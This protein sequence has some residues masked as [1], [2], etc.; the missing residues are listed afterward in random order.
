MFLGSG[1]ELIVFV[2]VI[3]VLCVLRIVGS[4]SPVG[5]LKQAWGRGGSG[6]QLYATTR[7]TILLV[8][9]LVAFR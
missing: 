7:R 9:Y 3:C 6:T 5:P 2:G 1:K 8:S 4:R